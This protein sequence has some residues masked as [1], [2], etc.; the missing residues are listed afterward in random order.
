MKRLLPLASL[1]NTTRRH[2]LT[3]K[4]FEMLV[5]MKPN[6]VGQRKVKNITVRVNI[7]YLLLCREKTPFKNL[8]VVKSIFLVLHVN[9]NIQNVLV[10]SFIW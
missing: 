5:V 2:A 4:N 6:K 8:Y 1:M 9:E 10:F 7:H 3:H